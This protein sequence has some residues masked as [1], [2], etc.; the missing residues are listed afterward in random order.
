MLL[1]NYLLL[2]FECFKNRNLNRKG[3]ILCCVFINDCNILI[4]YLSI[5]F[6]TN[7]KV[8]IRC[9]LC[10]SLELLKLAVVSTS[11]LT[12]R[13]QFSKEKFLSCWGRNIGKGRTSK[14]W[15]LQICSHHHAT[16]KNGEVK[17]K[18]KIDNRMKNLE[19]VRKI[20]WEN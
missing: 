17:S 20:W 3:Y 1:W 15:Q 11:I 9:S 14:V 18:K 16:G 2:P 19:S 5:Y 10:G 12:L 13:S 4:I 6:T 7:K 8:C